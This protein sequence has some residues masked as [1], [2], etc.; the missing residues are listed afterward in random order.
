MDTRLIPRV[1]F[2]R[3]PCLACSGSRAGGKGALFFFSHV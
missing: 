2:V 1:G 3:A